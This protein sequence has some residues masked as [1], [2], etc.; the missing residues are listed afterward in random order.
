MS[1]SNFLHT[2]VMTADT[3]FAPAVDKDGN[4]LTICVCA[5]VTISAK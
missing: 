3:G 4:Y 2:Y 5:K 1:L